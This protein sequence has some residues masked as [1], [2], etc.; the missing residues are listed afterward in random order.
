MFSAQAASGHVNPLRRQ[1][2]SFAVHEGSGGLEALFPVGT[3]SELRP[4]DFDGDGRF[5]RVSGLCN[6]SHPASTDGL[7]DFVGAEVCTNCNAHLFF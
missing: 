3:E 5:S 7:E 6:L 2:S 1:N 4:K